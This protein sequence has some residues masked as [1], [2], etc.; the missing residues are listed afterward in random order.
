MGGSGVGALAVRA[1]R[2]CPATDRSGCGPD[3]SLRITR[4]L[5]RATALG[6]A[7]SGRTATALCP[8]SSAGGNDQ[9]PTAEPWPR[10]E[11][12]HTHST[13]STESGRGATAARIAPVTESS[14]IP[15]GCQTHRTVRVVAGLKPGRLR[16]WRSLRRTRSTSS[17]WTAGSCGGG[18]QPASLA[19]GEPKGAPQVHWGR[20]WRVPK[21]RC[22][23][24]KP[25]GRGPTLRGAIPP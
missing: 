19:Y 21:K 20:S 12:S 15:G 6:T 4:A 11:A 25:A 2:I 13:A 5:S 1:T 16:G 10:T 18:A 14:R 8:N 3:P 24:V 23:S 7:C 9:P 22:R 17:T